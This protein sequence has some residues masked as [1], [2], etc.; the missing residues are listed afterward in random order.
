MVLYRQSYRPDHD[1]VYYF[2]LRR[3][4]DTNFVFHQSISDAI[5]VCD[6]MPASALDK[7]V[8]FAGE[9]WLE[10]NLLPLTLTD[11]D[12]AGGDSWRQN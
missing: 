8:T 10:R 1:C 5:F 9:V 11:F 12:Q 2:N 4:Q 3:A 7:V 6:N